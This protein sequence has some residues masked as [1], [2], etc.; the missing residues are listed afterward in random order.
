MTCLTLGS[1]ISDFAARNIFDSLK[2]PNY[3]PEPNNSSAVEME[4]MVRYK[5]SDNRIVHRCRLGLYAKMW[6]S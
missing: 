1:Y 4:M 3:V 2:A 6:R 5:L